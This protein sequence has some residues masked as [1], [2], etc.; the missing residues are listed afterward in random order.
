[1]Q[2][3]QPY[4]YKKI[5][6]TFFIIAVATGV[7]LSIVPRMIEQS[8]ARAETKAAWEQPFDETEIKGM[9]AYGTQYED[10]YWTEHNLKSF[11]VKAPNA[12]HDIPHEMYTTLN[13]ASSKEIIGI[14]VDE[15]PISFFQEHDMDAPTLEEYIEGSIQSTQRNSGEGWNVGKIKNTT[16]G[17]SPA[18]KR[19][20]TLTINSI[21]VY[22]VQLV[23]F[24]GDYYVELRYN[25]FYKAHEKQPDLLDNILSSI[26]IKKFGNEEAP[27]ATVD[28]EEKNL[29]ISDAEEYNFGSGPFV[30][31]SG[32]PIVTDLDIW[33]FNAVYRD[34]LPDIG[35][36]QKDNMEEAVED[37][38]GGQFLEMLHGPMINAEDFIVAHRAA[39]LNGKQQ[40]WTLFHIRLF[41]SDAASDN[42]IEA[43]K[44]KHYSDIITIFANCD[45]FFVDEGFQMVSISSSWNDEM[46][47]IVGYGIENDTFLD[48]F[49]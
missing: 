26:M 28:Q 15:T 3:K 33:W 1:M 40:P 48:N 37:V 7:L 18:L 8:R 21:P 25:S 17:G 13:I 36:I 43:N 39:I 23:F 34:N 30:E 45:T 41:Y 32:E 6:W 10:E 11:S 38:I 19:E 5:V 12:W 14:R 47:S 9:N 49:E 24:A 44:E 31:Y 29:K 2:M 46:K 22:I 42:E 35:E 20:S 4:N 16:I 27:G